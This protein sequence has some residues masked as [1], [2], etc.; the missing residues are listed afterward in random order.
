MGREHTKRNVVMKTDLDCIPCFFKQAQG[1]AKLAGADA[2][3]Q[4]KITGKIC[5]E[6]KKFSLNLCPSYMGRIIYNIVVDETGNKDPFCAAKRKSNILALRLYPEL[7]QKVESS[8]DKL[9]A[10]AELAVSG[11]IIDFGIKNSMKTEKELAGFLKG[12]F[13]TNFKYKKEFFYY[14]GFKE[15]VKCAKSILYIGDNAGEI[16]F[17][18]VLIEQIK[19]IWPNKEIIYV[20]K[21]RPIINDVLMEDARFCGLDKLVPVISSGCDAPGTIF[22]FCSKDFLKIYER[23]CL[24]IS[25]G[26]GNFEALSNK[27]KQVYFLFRA[28]CPVV[29]KNIGCGLGEVILR[30][31]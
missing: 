30:R 7:K 8:K 19:D 28:K 20:V 3:T 12:N 13:K 29:A 1:A 10:A 26:Q 4:R 16:V 21:D 27:K 14:P 15:A 18:K 5:K 31:N 11:N 23:C 25:K 2:E 24:V 22:E 17:D 6:L 9:L